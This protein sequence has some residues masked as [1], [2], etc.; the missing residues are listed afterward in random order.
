MF[1]LIIKKMNK[2]LKLFQKLRIWYKVNVST[3]DKNALKISVAT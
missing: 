2:N 3:T 1:I